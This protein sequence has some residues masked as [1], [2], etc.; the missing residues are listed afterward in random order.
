MEHFAHTEGI[1]PT[2]ARLSEAQKPH[3]RIIACLVNS[4]IAERHSEERQYGSLLVPGPRSDKDSL[5]ALC[6]WC[7]H[8][9][10]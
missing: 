10:S 7:M 1:C 4:A 5:T 8:S 6:G 9:L 3:R 2:A